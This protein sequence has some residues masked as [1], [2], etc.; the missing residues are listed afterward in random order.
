[1]Q[2]DW[3]IQGGPVM[4]PLL[5]CSLL[6]VGVT[7]ERAVFWLAWRRRRDPAAIDDLCAQAAGGARVSGVALDPVAGVCLEAAGSGDPL[8][9]LAAAGSGLVRSTRRFLR[10]HD[11][12]VTL[13]PMLGILGTVTGIISSFRVIGMGPVA[14]PEDVTGG[15]A[16]ALLT[17]AFG[18]V[19]AMLSLVPYNYFMG[20]SEEVA[21][22]V[23]EALTRFETSWIRG[24]R[25]G[26]EADP[27]AEAAP[28][29]AFAERGGAR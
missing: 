7:V 8:G 29:L 17:T 12:I 18:L 26:A 15:V 11:T 13:A 6:S 2:L 23:E 4:Y 16:E 14:A 20:R 27:G 21:V 25:A 3:F 19:I 24:H 1:M 5:V 10:I 22:E 9:H 28:R